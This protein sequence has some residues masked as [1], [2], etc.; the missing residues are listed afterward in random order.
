M[1]LHIGTQTDTL[2]SQPLDF[3][4]RVPRA[5][6][7]LGVG[8]A[9]YFPRE[10]FGAGD[11]GCGGAPPRRAVQSVQIVAAA[12]RTLHHLQRTAAAACRA[13]SPNLNLLLH[14]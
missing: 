1:T 3:A 4:K 10:D 8:G 14:S 12:L 7:G 9:R 6:A 13:P 11:P 2:Q 5:G